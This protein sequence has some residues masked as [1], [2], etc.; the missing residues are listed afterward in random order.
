MADQMT[1]GVTAVISMTAGYLKTRA[2]TVRNSLRTGVGLSPA[3]ALTFLFPLENG[4]WVVLGTM[5]VLRSSALATGTSVVRAVI[6]TVIGI[7][8]G[9]VVI[10]LLGVDPVVMWLLLPPVCFA[11][12][13][14][15]EI[16]SFAAGQAAFTMLVLI[17]FNLVVP[18]GWQLGLIRLQDVALGASVAVIASVLLWPRGATAWVES[19]IDTTCV[20][21]AL[22]AVGRLLRHPAL[23]GSDV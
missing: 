22:P 4:L 23:A 1:S 19:M 5:S 21:G 6:G 11:A 2:V 17:V 16:G 9:A 10:G 15:P 12:A 7:A 3:V 8:I 14:V 20:V 18:T 13:Y